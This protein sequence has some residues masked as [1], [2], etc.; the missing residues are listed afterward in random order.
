MNTTMSKYVKLSK[1]NSK[2][3]RQ[4]KLTDYLIHRRLTKKSWQMSQ[5]ERAQL[6]V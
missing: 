4:P 6:K 3:S 2:L 1:E 5:V